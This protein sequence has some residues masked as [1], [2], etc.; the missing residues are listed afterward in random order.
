[1]RGVCE[2]TGAALDMS[3]VRGPRTPHLDRINPKKGYTYKN[4]RWVCGVFNFAKQNWTDEDVFSVFRGDANPTA[5]K[6]R[7][8]KASNKAEEY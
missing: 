5:R 2:A 1:M 7:A 6:S 4:V 8:A 3:Q